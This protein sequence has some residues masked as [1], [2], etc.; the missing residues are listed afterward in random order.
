MGIGDFFNPNS[1]LD[2]GYL[3][4]T[5]SY[6]PF[7]YA[8]CIAK[9]DAL[10]GIEASRRVDLGI[11]KQRLEWVARYISYAY[12]AAEQPWT[13]RDISEVRRTIRNAQEECREAIELCKDEID[14]ID[15][16][17]LVKKLVAKELEKATAPDQPTSKS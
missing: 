14:R 15:R 8:G 13:N 1:I 2:L 16:D 6:E 5:N 7:G 9:T 4:M 3:S 17:V 12:N 11:A 10:V